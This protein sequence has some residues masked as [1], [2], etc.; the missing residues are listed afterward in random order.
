MTTGADVAS[1]IRDHPD[2]VDLLLSFTWSASQGDE[3]RFNPYPVGVETRYFDDQ[4]REVLLHLMNNGDETK[5]NPKAV[6]DVLQF[7]PAVKDLQKLSDSASIKSYLD[8]LNR[9]AFPL[10]RWVITSNRAHLA[11]LGKKEV[12]CYELT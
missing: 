10:L 6:S 7:L 5:R 4:Q 8:E 11:R 12:S 9:L 1:E 2:V 3:R